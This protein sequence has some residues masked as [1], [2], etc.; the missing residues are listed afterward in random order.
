MSWAKEQ[1]TILIDEHQKYPSLY[2]VKSKEYKNK[3]SRTQALES[4]EKVIRAVRKD[5]TVNE[6]KNKFHG[7]KT[8]FL[9]ECR[10]HEQSLKSGAGDDDIYYP[11][12]WYYERMFFIRDHNI[13]RPG[14][15]NIRESFNNS[16]ENDENEHIPF[17]E[18]VENNIEDDTI[19]VDNRSITEYE[20]QP[21]N[22]LRPV[23]RTIVQ[24]ESSDTSR[25]NS[26]MSKREGKQTMNGRK[27]RT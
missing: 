21:D 19:Q 18:A 23:N 1:V 24:D 7:L 5:V 10:K 13:P 25:V 8:T 17:T 11:T 16:Q 2:A 6:I 20:I 15:D 26:P 14:K 3:H 9:N 22:T 27:K 12:I 4:I